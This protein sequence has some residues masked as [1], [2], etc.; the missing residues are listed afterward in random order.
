MAL[1]QTLGVASCLGGPLRTC[2]YAAE[3]LHEEFTRQKTGKRPQ[4]QWHMV[5]PE[6]QGSKY[7]KL[8]RL[9]QAVSRFS[10]YWTERKQA[11]LVI[12]GDHSCALGTWGGVMNALQQPG[13]FGL[14]WLDAHMDSHTFATSPS[15][16]IHGMPLAALLGKADKKLAAMYPGSAFI[17][18]ENL[19]LIGVRSYEY[20]EYDLLQQAGVEIVF[21]GQIDRLAP[22]LIKAVDRLSRSCELIGISIDL[23]FIDPGDAPGVETPAPDGIKAEE[24]LE[25]LSSINRHP[26]IGGLEISEFNPEKDDNNKTLYLMKAIVEIF[27][28]ETS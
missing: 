12:G 21:A 23:D 22:V 4:L 26:K 8:S 13:K 2:G 11:F 25:A 9:N 15:G 7:E 6:S 16:N 1:L 20:Q 10:Q 14:I 18:P 28:G 19:I 3:M 24:L 5:Y 17:K 27:Y